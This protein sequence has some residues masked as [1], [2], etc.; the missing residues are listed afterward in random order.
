MQNFGG[1]NFDDSTGICQISSDFS[2]VKV[3]RYTVPHHTIVRCDK[4][5]AK[6]SIIYNASVQTKGLSLNDCLQNGLKFNQTIIETLVHFCWYPVAWI[7]DTDKVF[8]NFYD[9]NVSRASECTALF[10]G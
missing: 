6:V 9:I 3:L 2:T 8:H 4:E 10:V 1:K 5:T 7:A